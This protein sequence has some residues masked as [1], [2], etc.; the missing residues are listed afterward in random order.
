LKFL[1]GEYLHLGYLYLWCYGLSKEDVLGLGNEN[2]SEEIQFKAANFVYGAEEFINF[3]K[4]N[5]VSVIVDI[6]RILSGPNG[7][8]DPFYLLQVRAGL[9][10]FLLRFQ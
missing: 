4:R 9:S 5:L 7:L 2:K 3:F 1:E 10:W 8:Q 6:Y